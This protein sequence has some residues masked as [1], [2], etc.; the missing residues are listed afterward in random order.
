MALK[1]GNQVLLRYAYTNRTCKYF[2]TGISI[3]VSDLKR[4]VVQKPVRSTNPNAAHL[5][6]MAEQV[7]SKIMSIESQLLREEKIP[8]AGLVHELYHKAQLLEVNKQFRLPDLVEQYYNRQLKKL[9]GLDLNLEWLAYDEAGNKYFKQAGIQDVISNHACCRTAISYLERQGYT[10]PDVARI[11][12]KS[13]PTI[14]KYYL[15]RTTQ[16]N[17]VETQRSISGNTAR[18]RISS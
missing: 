7:Y 1:I 15:G 5:N 6:R 10:L 4:E 17:I 11:F 2:S 16:S 8:T 18:M 12:G 9:A 3:P 14:M 13:L